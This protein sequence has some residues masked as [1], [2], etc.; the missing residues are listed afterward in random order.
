MGQPITTDIEQYIL[1]KSFDTNVQ[2][3]AMVQ[4][5]QDIN[6]PTILRRIQVDGNGILQTTTEE[7]TSAVEYD[8]SGN[9]IYTGFAAP[10]TAKSASLWKIRKITYDVNGN[11]TDIQWADG[12]TQF[13]KVWNSRATYTYS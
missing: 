3:L 8:G 2:T 4:I 9:P 12:D 7:Y 13:D 5:G 6:N 10:G 11:P 1:N